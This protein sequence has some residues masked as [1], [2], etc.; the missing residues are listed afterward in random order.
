MEQHL[1]AETLD[2]VQQL[3]RSARSDL[4]AFWFPLVV[5][6]CI[7]VLSAAVVAGTGAEALGVYWA[8]FGTAGGVLTG[9]H[10]SR[11]EQ[12]LGVKGP[13][14]AYVAT[15]I[16]ILVGAMLAG[17][18]GSQSGSGL[19]GAV[20]P[21]MVVAAGYLVFALLE[22]STALLALAGVMLALAVGVAFSGMDAEP[23]TVVLSLTTGTASLL[24]GLSHRPS[25]SHRG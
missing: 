17:V 16:A 5:F 20:G 11:R 19:A 6:G 2:R 25:T 15:A 14:A 3:R 1:A 8:V 13:A 12:L 22:R 24:T 10:Y 7:T 9:W 23:A 18:F 4:R 21:S